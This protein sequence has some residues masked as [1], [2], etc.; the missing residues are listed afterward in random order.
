MKKAIIIIG[1]VGVI[2]AGIGYY[3]Y[4]R[5]NK[6]ADK[7]FDGMIA[8]TK[9]KGYDVFEDISPRELG[10]IKNNYLKYFNRELHNEFMNL[11]SI[12]EATWSASQKVKFNNH[13]NKILKG[14]RG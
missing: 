1:V 2:G 7:D 12:G 3:M 8:L 14:L 10:I 9:N 4:K 11:L 6:L 5:Q 13:L